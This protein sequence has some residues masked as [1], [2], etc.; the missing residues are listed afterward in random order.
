[1]KDTN[2]TQEKYREYIAKYGDED[3]KAVADKSTDLKKIYKKLRNEE[4]HMKEYLLKDT[5]GMSWSKGE[6]VQVPG[7]AW[8]TA[9]LTYSPEAILRQEYIEKHYPRVE[10]SAS[11]PPRQIFADEP[12]VHAKD[13]VKQYKEKI[14]L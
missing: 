12:M 4:Y 11:Y 10:G 6:W 5:S 1:M 7:M 2:K 14:Q 9:K 3:L 8:S 13:I